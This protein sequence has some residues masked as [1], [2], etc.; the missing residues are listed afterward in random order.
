MLI[1]NRA[2]QLNKLILDY[3]YSPGFIEAR[4][5]IREGS[6]K[7]PKTKIGIHNFYASLITRGCGDYNTS[8]FADM[9]ESCG[10]VLRSDVNEDGLLISLKCNTE[11]KEKL[12][13]LIVDMIQSPHLDSDQISLE[14]QLT[15]QTIKRQKENHF[16]VAF[17]NWRKIAFADTFYKYD[18]IGLDKDISN[19]T[20]NDLYNLS[21]IVK[22]RDKYLVI[23][24]FDS[25]LLSQSFIENNFS[26]LADRKRFI[27]KESQIMNNIIETTLPRIVLH[28]T[29]TSQVTIMYGH[30]TVSHNHQDDLILRLLA[31]HLGNG[32]SSVLFKVLREDF[33]VTYDAGIYNPIFEYHTPFLIH[34][35]TTTEKAILTFTLIKSILNKVLEKPLTSKELHLAKAKL[36]GNYALNSQTIGQKAERK[37]ILLGF[38]MPDDHDDIC[39]ARM[40]G[41]TSLEILDVAQKYLRNPFISLSGPKAVINSIREKA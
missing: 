36:K 4:L 9:I 27:K 10:A 2:V 31:S 6:R 14:R 7:D 13:P 33:G 20:R 39:L 8:D 23:S 17:N 16:Q 29:Q 19:I 28:E 37:A 15:M 11:D 38:K 18:P 32:M 26:I 22:N 12:L 3:K 5:W 30:K 24:G 41:V 21:N 25:N 40:Q 34:A 1:Q 35:S